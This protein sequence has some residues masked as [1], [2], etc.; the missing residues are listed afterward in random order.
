MLEI[1]KIWFSDTFMPMRLCFMIFI[2]GV[3][4][5]P[6]CTESQEEIDR[7]VMEVYEK[8]VAEFSSQRLEACRLDALR[9]AEELADSII[10]SLS[11]N[12][13]RDSLYRPVI[14]AR[15][16]FIPVDTAVF[17]SKRSVKPIIG[18]DSER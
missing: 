3:T 8:R 9:L 11:L 13:L 12:P 16:D 10:L 5:S 14:P 15:P 4:L 17:D 18:E 6:G 2:V 1:D 7:Q